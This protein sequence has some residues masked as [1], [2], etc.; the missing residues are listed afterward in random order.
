MWDFNGNIL[1]NTVT[2]FLLA[3]MTASLFFI[4]IKDPLIE[5]RRSFK[6]YC[7]LLVFFFIY[8]LADTA[9]YLSVNLECSVTVINI[10]FCLYVFA[11]FISMIPT[12]NWAKALIEEKRGIKKTHFTVFKA[13]C[14]IV[15]ILYLFAVF[16]AK[17]DV[18]EMYFSET[19]FPI[20]IRLYI[21]CCILY[22]CSLVFLIIYRKYIGKTETTAL[23]LF[24]V[25]NLI[26]Y[27]QQYWRDVP[28]NIFSTALMFAIY[29]DI[30]QKRKDELA[31]Q[32]ILLVRQQQELAEKELELTNA[33]VTLMMS[34]IQPHFL[35][36]TLSSI[37]FLCTKDP[38]KAR[39]VTNDFVVYLRGNLNALS[40]QKLI[41]FSEELEHI[42]T[43][44][45]IEKVRFGEAL[46]MEFDIRATDFSVPAL[47]IQPLVEN[48]VKHGVCKKVGGGTVCIKSRD[49][50]SGYV[51]TISDNGSG[52]DTSEVN[53]SDGT[54]HGIDN[55]RKRVEYQCGGSVEIESTPG[56]GTT[57]TVTIPK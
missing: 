6:Y 24:I 8:L 2:N 15:P 22:A 32:N 47:S 19:V 46:S 39:Q 57:V 31:M 37:S 28:G 11:S 9:C 18:K 48:A 12:V 3:V 4:C 10:S 36:N 30:W 50:G 1:L 17:M 45:K 54:H 23:I 20:M 33:R 42:K 13:V 38:Q 49:T 7:R 53:W 51:I 27:A 25:T 35:Y 34:Q 52:F 26:F 29:V 5:Q 43:Y 56:E 55:S 40:S 44:L 14:I 41:P 21:V 16:H